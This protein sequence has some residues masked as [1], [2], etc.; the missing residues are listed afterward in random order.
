MD[1]VD[2]FIAAL[3]HLAKDRGAQTNVA[4]DSG[5]SEAYI[6]QLANKK[7]INPSRKA[8]AKIAAA[9]KISHEDMMALGKSLL[10]Q[11][12]QT[13]PAIHLICEHQAEYTYNHLIADVGAILASGDGEIISALSSYVRNSK[14]ALAERKKLNA[15]EVELEKNRQEMADLRRTVDRLSSSDA[16]TARQAASSVSGET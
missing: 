4:M 11:P 7:R 13:P 14:R 16:G 2:Y 6:S 10:D 5:L 3:R 15:C 12:D 8:L 9:L 1:N